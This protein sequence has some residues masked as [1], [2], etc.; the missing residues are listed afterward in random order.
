[1]KSATNAGPLPLNAAQSHDTDM[2]ITFNNVNGYTGLKTG[3]GRRKNAKHL[4]KVSREAPAVEKIP[5]QTAAV[6]AG[7]LQLRRK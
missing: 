6:G 1:M 5:Q 3:P 2:T 7:Y 4:P